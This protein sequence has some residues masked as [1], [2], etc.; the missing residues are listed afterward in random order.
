MN[1]LKNKNLRRIAFGL[2]FSGAVMGTGS[3]ASVRSGL[4][5]DWQ[6]KPINFVVSKNPDLDLPVRESSPFFREELDQP[7]KFEPP[8]ARPL[9]LVQRR[10]NQREEG[11][12]IERRGKRERRGEGGSEKR[13]RGVPFIDSHMHFI[14]DT[15]SGD[16]YDGA[17]DVATDTMDRNNILR[18]IVMPPPFTP[19]KSGKHDHEELL[20]AARRHK[21]RFAV[22]GGGG[23]LNVMIQEAVAKGAVDDALKAEFTARAEKILADGA[24][25]FGEMAALHL[26][27]REGHPFQ[28]APP[29]HPLFLL[30]AEI[31][32]R[33]KV[34]IDWHMEAVAADRDIPEHIKGAPNPDRLSA[35]IGAF[36]RLLDHA[37][38][39]T[40]IWDH[41]GWDNTGER[42]VA[43][44][45][46]L[47]KAHP[48]LVMN[49]KVAGGSLT[50]NRALP[51]GGGL[52]D[53]WRVLILE[54]PDRFLIGSDVKTRP[55]NSRS[56][57]NE[58]PRGVSRLL[59]E[60]PP[61]VARQI[62]IE[63][64]KRVFHLD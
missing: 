61:R 60:L 1:L 49:F 31:A 22:L 40:I 10:R 29:D 44:A 26:S 21:G 18:S 36:E 30:L 42:T 63:N 56:R 59:R 58:S 51:K 23:S 54:F 48:N 4:V 11:G 9:I 39:A 53:E 33:H 15:R 35:N 24:I 41:L 50:V 14:G 43:L 13:G 34:P 52:G 2:T 57:T 47:L 7:V 17:G 6:T 5:Q 38:G 12:K 3:A 45:R 27:L 32:Q 20:E 46:R 16:D 62:A 37:P 28:M 55:P 8:I 19:G 64:P 25:G